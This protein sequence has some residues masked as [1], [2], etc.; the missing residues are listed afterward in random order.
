MDLNFSRSIVSWYLQNKRDLPWR[1]TRDPYKI[2]VSEIILQQTR[3]AQ[4]LSY[5]L[6]F[7]EHFPT[8][9]DLAN[10]PEDEVLLLWQGLG[11]YSR[12]RNMHSAAKSI[13]DNHNGIFPDSYD[14]IRS[15]KGV[16]DYTA[17]AI[18]S[19]AFNLPHAT[20]DGNV[21]RLLSRYFSIETPIDSTM[22]KKEFSLLAQSLLDP[23]NAALHNQ[24]MMDLGATICL[25][26]SPKCEVCPLA[27]SCSSFANHSQGQFPVKEKKLKTKDRYFLY[28]KVND[29]GHTYLRKRTEKDIWQGLYEFPLVET[30]H[31]ICDQDW[32][33]LICQLSKEFQI[34]SID[35]RYAPLTHILSHQKIHAWFA[36]VSGTAIKGESQ[37]V[38][39]EESQVGEFAVSRLTELLLEKTS[40]TDLFAH[41]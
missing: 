27:H 24:G 26:T 20:L 9:I 28:V 11:Y 40:H 1:N 31:P 30:D 4:G 37:F 7:I 2:W 41:K 14:K 35:R 17:A 32:D 33:K 18:A 29:Q 12:A 38:K 15:L 8:V 16:G 13:A 19:F 21:F 23:Q 25:S 5:Y 36:E 6:R 10:A 3:I 34:S 39:I 22:G